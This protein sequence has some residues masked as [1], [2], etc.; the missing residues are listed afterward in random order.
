MNIA[1]R[2][3]PHTSVS[4]KHAEY[5]LIGLANKGRVLFEGSIVL[6]PISKLVIW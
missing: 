1:K 6:F 4:L 2:C 3:Y 5:F